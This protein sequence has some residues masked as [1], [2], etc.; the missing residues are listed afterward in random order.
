MAGIRG[1]G[2]GGSETLL[3]HCPRHQM[4]VANGLIDNSTAVPLPVSA[5]SIILMPPLTP[6]SS[7]PN[8]SG[9]YRWSLDLRYNVTGQPTG[10]DQFPEFVA[11]SRINPGNGLSDWMEW[12]SLWESAR[13]RL[14]SSPHIP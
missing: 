4:T 1:D 7:L 5:N 9:S 10:R 11:R 14:A 13:R 6:L 2:T 3:Q 12:R 8:H